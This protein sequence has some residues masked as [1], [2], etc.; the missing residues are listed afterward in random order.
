M[1]PTEQGARL[2]FALWML[3]TDVQGLRN[4]MEQLSNE[5]LAAWLERSKISKLFEEVEELVQFVEECDSTD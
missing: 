2:D 3:T 5:E 1:I 4:R